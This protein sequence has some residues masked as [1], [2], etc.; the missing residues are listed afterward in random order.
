[1]QGFK[2]SYGVIE[3]MSKNIVTGAARIFEGILFTGLVSYSIKF[4]LDFASRFLCEH[5][6]APTSYSNMLVSAH[7]ISM[8]WFPLILPLTTTAW[9]T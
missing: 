2:V 9:S 5:T 3:T 8:K 6:L 7:G 4:G 1:M